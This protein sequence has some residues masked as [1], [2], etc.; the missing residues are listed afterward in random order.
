M[1]KRLTEG[2]VQPKWMYDSLW[3]DF[4]DIQHDINRQNFKKLA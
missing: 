2:P 1:E 3:N 4:N